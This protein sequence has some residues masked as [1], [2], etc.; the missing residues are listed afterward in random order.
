MNVKLKFQLNSYESLGDDSGNKLVGGFSGSISMYT[1]P[2]DSDD[3]G[4]ANN[5]SGGNCV[6]NCGTGQNVNCNT[7][8]GCGTHG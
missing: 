7:T 8:T 1:D 6:A 2:N 4:G 3:G 5:C